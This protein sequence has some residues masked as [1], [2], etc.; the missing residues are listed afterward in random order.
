MLTQVQRAAVETIAQ[1]L[2]YGIYLETLIQCLRWLVFIDEGWKPRD[3]INSLIMT[4]ATS[5]IF[6]TSTINLM[7]SLQYTLGILRRDENWQLNGIGIA[8]DISEYLTLLSI[9]CVLIYRCWIVYGNSWRVICVPV[10][11]CI[12]S[13]ACSALSSYYGMY[14]GKLDFSAVQSE[15][16]ALIG[17]YVCNI[18]TTIYTTTAIIYR[19]WY[20]TKT[21]GG[22]PK[23]LNYIM[24]ILAE[25]GILYTCTIIFRLA[26]AVLVTRDDVTWVNLLTQ[27]IS[28]AI[29]FST[30]G[31]SFNL[32]LMRVNQGRL[33]LRGSLAESIN[34]D[35]VRILSGIE[36]NNPQITA[37]SEGPPSNARQ[38]DKVIDEIQEHR[39]SSITVNQ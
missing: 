20:T 13:L 29:N 18:A 12:G 10:T 22:S 15:E 34:V 30:A 38:V 36:F 16:K 7:T 31:I 2:L 17:L 21:S 5:F 32:L 4:F 37:S 9:D 11:F 23:R 27:D 6:L 19:I 33:E 3:K 28:D 35:G 25:S 1:A 14:S 8:M 39:R 24:R 26:G